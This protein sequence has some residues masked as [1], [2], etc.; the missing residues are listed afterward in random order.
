MISFKGRLNRK[1]FLIQSVIVGLI[2]FLNVIVISFVQKSLASTADT[3]LALLSLPISLI[4][5]AISI[6][7]VIFSISISIKRWH[8]I[9]KS[10]WWT[11]T[12]IIPIVNILVWFYLIFKKGD[13]GSNQFGPPQ[14]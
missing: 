1:A 7:V 4:S 6:C 8:D 2:Q 11:L 9:G 3:S 14:K 12:T 5:I 13:I 10:G